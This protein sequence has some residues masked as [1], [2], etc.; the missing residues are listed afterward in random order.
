MVVTQKPR[1]HVGMEHRI[2]VT[3][4]SSLLNPC[5]RA[6]LFSYEGPLQA[7]VHDT[8]V[9]SYPIQARNYARLHESLAP[10]GIHLEHVWAGKFTDNTG[11]TRAHWVARDE[12]SAVYWQKS[13]SMA[14]GT[15]HNHV[16]IHGARMKLTAWLAMTPQQQAQALGKEAPPVGL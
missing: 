14:P 7:F 2:R 3:P 8:L 9:P 16:Y 12:T 6:D 10:H 11:A 13:E 5:T 15:G 1:K 4:R